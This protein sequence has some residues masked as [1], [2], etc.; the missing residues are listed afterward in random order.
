[1]FFVSCRFL[2]QCLLV[3]LKT[4]F[5]NIP[6]LKP[7]LLLFLA[8]SCFFCCVCFC[9]G[10]VY[11]CLSGS[12]LVLCLVFFCLFLF[13]FCL[14]SWFAFSGS[15][16]EK[17]NWFSCNSGVFELCWLKGRL[18]IMFYLL[19]SLDVSCV[20][21]FVC[22]LNNEVALFCICIVCFLFFVTRLC[23]FWFA[24]CGLVSFCCCVFNFVFAFHSFR[25]R[26]KWTRHPPQKKSEKE[27]QLAQLCSQI[28]FLFLGWATTLHFC[29]NPTK[30]VVSTAFEKENCAKK[31]EKG[32]VKHV[33]QHNWT[34]FWLKK[35]YVLS[36][37]SFFM[38][39][40]FSLQKEEDF[41]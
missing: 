39:I 37:F 18:L 17:K 33:A 5:P 29:W 12:M 6:F 3:S 22:S 23:G 9:F 20:V 25:R 16:Y 28:V 26:K 31:R 8:V 13:G 35:G 4:N 38:N 15:I 36:S 27:N 41:W 11:F 40:S 19:F 7:K 10:G 1:M 14:V 21:L 34:D 2:S 24:S 30:I 32:W